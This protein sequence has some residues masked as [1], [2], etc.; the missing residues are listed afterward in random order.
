[1]SSMESRLQNS[2]TT[3]EQNRI[4]SNG[5]RVCQKNNRTNKVQDL[6]H[7]GFSTENNRNYDTIQPM[8]YSV[9]Q[10]TRPYPKNKAAVPDVPRYGDLL[11]TQRVVQ[12]L[13][14]ISGKKTKQKTTSSSIFETKNASFPVVA[15][16]KQAKCLSLLLI[17][18]LSTFEDNKRNG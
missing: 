16:I 17:D 11:S 6:A 3:K 7:N 15:E 10:E 12:V 18:L 8:K 9:P 5:V 4:S 14:F 1:M 2:T 13:I